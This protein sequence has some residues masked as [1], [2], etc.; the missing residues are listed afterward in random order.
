MT[1][2]TAIE[3]IGVCLFVLVTLVTIRQKQRI[4]PDYGFWANITLVLFVF[5]VILYHFF[6]WLLFVILGFPILIINIYLNTHRIFSRT[7]HNLKGIPYN[8]PLDE[9]S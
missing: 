7:Y 8:E 6:P 3:I 4:D 5:T 9:E 1:T 2:Q